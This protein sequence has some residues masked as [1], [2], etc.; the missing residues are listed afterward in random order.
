MKPPKQKSAADLQKQID[1]FNSAIK[2]GDTVNVKDDDGNT[3]QDIIS[4][5][6]TI[7]GG[8]TAMAWLEG[9][10]SYM[11]DRVLSKA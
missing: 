6:A 11:L 3:F 5:P 1:L 4:H 10:G 7:M 8:H 2:P 9:K